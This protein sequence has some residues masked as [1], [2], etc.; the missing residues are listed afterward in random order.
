MILV[1]ILL[2]QSAPLIAP[3]GGA[4]HL[5]QITDI[6]PPPLPPF[7]FIITA[8]G[9]TVYVQCRQYGILKHC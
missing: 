7:T 5:E 3:G 4:C 6:V 1:M 9:S 2:L 8:A